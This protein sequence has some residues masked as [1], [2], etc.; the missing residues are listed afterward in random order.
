MHETRLNPT[1]PGEEVARN[2]GKLR[3]KA[4]EPTVRLE[5]TIC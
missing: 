4:M 3:R 2:G 5:L 1:K